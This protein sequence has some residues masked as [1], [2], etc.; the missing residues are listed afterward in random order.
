MSQES[1]LALLNKRVIDIRVGGLQEIK[2]PIRPDKTYILYAKVTV[3]R[4]KL[5]L[6][7]GIGYTKDIYKFPNYWLLTLITFSFLTIIS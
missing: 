1:I 4:I 6:C 5:Y 2:F 3:E 7:I